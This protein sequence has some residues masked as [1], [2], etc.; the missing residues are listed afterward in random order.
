MRLS[1][2]HVSNATIRTRCLMRSTILWVLR[3]LR[4]PASDDGN[5]VPSI[6]RVMLRDRGYFFNDIGQPAFYEC[7]TV[8]GSLFAFFLPAF[9]RD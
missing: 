1:T 7:L 9:L 2:F 4:V 8:V 6:T 3:V 5:D